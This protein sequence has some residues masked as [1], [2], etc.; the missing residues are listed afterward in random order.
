MIRAS[1]FDRVLLRPR[2]TG[3]QL[4]GQEL[5]LRRIGRFAQGI[6]VLV[7]AWQEL[8][9][10]LDPARQ[11]VLRLVGS[12]GNDVLL[13]YGD[14]GDPQLPHPRRQL[15]GAVSDL[16]LPDNFR[17]F[18]TWIVP[19]ACITYY[20]AL[21]IIGRIDPKSTSIG[22][23]TP[24]ASPIFLLISLR[25]WRFGVSHYRSTGS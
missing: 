14:D 16:H 17:R 3:L 6:L 1:T 19:L 20:P 9:L 7:W 21:A 2:S 15:Y 8:G 25:L 10:G 11:S 5:Q 22:W 13:D 4:M 24:L 23:V 18:F 12:G